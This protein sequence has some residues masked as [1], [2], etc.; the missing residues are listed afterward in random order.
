MNIGV[1][2]GNNG[3]WFGTLAYITGGMIKKITLMLLICI[4]ILFLHL[5]HSYVGDLFCSVEEE[6]DEKNLLGYDFTIPVWE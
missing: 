1:D 4:K 5:C 2:E 6:L 3:K